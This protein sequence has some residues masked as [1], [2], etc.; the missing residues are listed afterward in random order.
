MEIYLEPFAETGVKSVGV[1][2]ASGGE[3]GGGL[4]D[5]GDDHGSDE[6]AQSAGDRVQEG[7]E[8]EMAQAAQDGGDMAVR[9]GAGDEEGIGQGRAEGGQR[10]RQS[11]AEG[12][13]LMR[14]EMG[15]VGESA[16]LDLA[17]KAE[18]LAQQD[19]GR[20]RAVRDGGQIHAYILSH[21][22]Q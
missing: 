5:A 6:V 12:F 15:E 22:L 13:N 20:G 14:G 16:R 4:E 18:G 2:A 11:Q 19:G 10:A 21:K 1:K 8:L 17:A 3:L 7:I 9:E